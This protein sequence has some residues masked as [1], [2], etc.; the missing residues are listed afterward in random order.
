MTAV[1]IASALILFQATMALVRGGME[2]TI[3]PARRRAL[4][5]KVRD[6]EYKFAAE[7]E[8]HPSLRS[9]G[10]VGGV[11]SATLLGYLALNLLNYV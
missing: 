10:F 3:T 5:D 2:M 4:A 7:S 1:N 9:A 8:C 11:L 6:K